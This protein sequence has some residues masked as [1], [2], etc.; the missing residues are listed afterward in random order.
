MNGSAVRYYSCF[1]NN[2]MGFNSEYLLLWFFIIYE[3]NENFSIYNI[4]YINQSI[5]KLTILS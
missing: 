1:K 2:P 5:E 3:I 4:V